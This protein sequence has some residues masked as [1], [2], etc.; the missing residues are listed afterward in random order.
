MNP[1]CQ[2]T[3]ALLPPHIQVSHNNRVFANEDLSEAFKT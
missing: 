3:K 2:V 1:L